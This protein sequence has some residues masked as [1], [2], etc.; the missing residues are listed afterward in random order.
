MPST[1]NPEALTSLDNLKTAISIT[2]TSKDAFLEQLINR[3]TAWIESRTDRK[4]KARQYNGFTGG[5]ATLGVHAT[6]SVPDE[7]Y[8]YLSGSPRDIGGDAMTDERG[9]G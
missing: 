2:N 9:Y 6:T 8:L 5:A 1:L 4:L 7:D 3:A